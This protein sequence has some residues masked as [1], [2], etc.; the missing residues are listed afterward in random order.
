MNLNK[1]FLIGRVTGDIQ[2]RATPSNQSVA[3]FSIAT[4]RVWNDKN[5]Q[6]QESTEF[7]NIVAWGRNAEIASQFLSKGSLVMI[8]GRLQTRSWEGNDGQKRKTTEIVCERLQLGP[9][10]ASSSY[11]V[12][13]TEPAI[14]KGRSVKEFEDSLESGLEEIKVDD[15]GDEINPEDLPF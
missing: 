12:P 14:D 3:N 11:S 9:R 8:E 1:V 15:S 7:H 6:K 2:L 4:N 10:N 13:A 5:G